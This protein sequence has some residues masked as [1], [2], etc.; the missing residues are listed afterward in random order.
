MQIR[1]SNGQLFE[2]SSAA[3]AGRQRAYSF[4]REPITCNIVME[5]DHGPTHDR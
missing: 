3:K 1:S 4:K 5:S 2:M